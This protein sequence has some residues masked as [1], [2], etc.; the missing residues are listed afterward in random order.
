V[1][2]LISVLPM[3]A[4]ILPIFLAIFTVTGKVNWGQLNS[5]LEITKYTIMLQTALCMLAVVVSRRPGQDKLLKLALLYVFNAIAVPVYIYFEAKRDYQESGHSAD[6]QSAVS[7]GCDSGGGDIMVGCSLNITWGKLLL[8]YLFVFVFGMMFTLGIKL[9]QSQYGYGPVKAKV[10]MSSKSDVQKVLDRY[11]N[12]NKISPS[13]SGTPREISL[14]QFIVP[15]ELV[16][17]I[18]QSPTVTSLEIVDSILKKDQLKVLADALELRLVKLSGSNVTDQDAEALLNEPMS[19]VIIDNT[20]ISPE[21]V[22]KLAGLSS[23]RYMSAAG[24]GVTLDD[25]QLI[26]EKS[27]KFISKLNRCVSS[28]VK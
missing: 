14:F 4:F 26:V 3:L 28:V 22:I 8:S 15:D 20:S 2:T 21:Y 24:L 16:D 1:L 9:Q 25:L 6:A 12:Q 5:A 7:C 19:A 10:Q 13:G 23:V 17:V 18:A 27:R 11:I